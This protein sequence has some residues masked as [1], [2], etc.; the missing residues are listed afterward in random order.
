M[1]EKRNEVS[2][3]LQR[4]LPELISGERRQ[5]ALQ[6]PLPRCPKTVAC[7][8]FRHMQADESLLLE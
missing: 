1:L 2:L 7:F 3:L 4:K 5:I 8:E 6:S